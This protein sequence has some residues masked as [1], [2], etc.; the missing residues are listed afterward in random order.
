MTNRWEYKWE[1]NIES[2][3]LTTFPDSNEKMKEWLDIK[4][5]EG[6]ELVSIDWIDD[7]QEFYFKR[8]IDDSVKKGID[9]GAVDKTSIDSA[10]EKP[11]KKT[12]HAADLDAYMNYIPSHRG[13]DIPHHRK[14]PR[15]AANC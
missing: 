15:A 14:R 1:Y 5:N 10:Y 6:W 11:D 8:R 13:K 3:P 2:R 9:F 7:D 4:G 12:D